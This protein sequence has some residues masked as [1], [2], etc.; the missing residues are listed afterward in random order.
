[1]KVGLPVGINRISTKILIEIS[2]GELV[3]R[4]TIL[5]LKSA[6]ITDPQKCERVRSELVRHESLIETLPSEVAL[7]PL[8]DRLFA[9]NARLWE[10]EDNIRACD[11]TQ[12]FG[13]RFI[14]LARDVYR[15]NTERFVTKREIDQLLGSPLSEVKSYGVGDGGETG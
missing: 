13:P 3:D 4:T 12:D 7:G 5:R 10:I 2:P 9:I 6:H 1:M 11:R 15:T 14:Q 8:V